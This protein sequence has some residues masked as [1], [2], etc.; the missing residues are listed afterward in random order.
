[1]EDENKT[2]PNEWV[3]AYGDLVTLLMTFF[4]L[5]I[6]MSVMDTE[7]LSEVLN[8][9]RGSGLGI[10]TSDLRE[11]GLFNEKV[12]SQSRLKIDKP[13]LPS[14]I[15]D[16]DLISEAVVVFITESDSAKMIDFKRTEEGFVIIIRAGLLFESGGVELKKECLYLL[17]GLAELLGSVENNIKITGHTDD[18]YSDDDYF[19]NKISIERATSVCRFFAEEGMMYPARFGV[20]GYG[21]YKPLLPNIS[22]SNRAKNRRV[23]IIVEEVPRNE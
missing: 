17:N 19:D 11:S 22:E 10:L 3:L 9:N 23:E 15:N 14:P 7:K 8:F 16:L 21:R 1:M 6:S 5:I 4:V 18:R 2:D 13:E 12:V 20:S